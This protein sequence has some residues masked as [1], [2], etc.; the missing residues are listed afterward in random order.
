ML[1][2]KEEQVRSI[3]GEPWPRMP[4]AFDPIRGTLAEVPATEAP[5]WRHTVYA[6]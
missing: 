3:P 1:T 6:P 4:K 2:G 5:T